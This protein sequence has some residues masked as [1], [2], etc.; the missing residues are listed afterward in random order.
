MRKKEK[1]QNKIISV[2][3]NTI[4]S[5]N[6]EDIK[7][8]KK[9]R[10]WTKNK[11][12][13]VDFLIILS[14]VMLDQLIKYYASTTLEQH[15]SI[16]LWEG[17]LQLTYL[18]NTGGIFGILQNQNF[19]ILFVVVILVLVVLYLLTKLPDKPRFTKLHI[20]LSCLLAGALGNLTDRI[21]F[22]YVIDF[23]YFVGIDFPIFNGADIL[24]STSTV[25][26]IIL[27]VFYY[28]EKD[29]D[30]LNFKQKR[31]RELK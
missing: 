15:G 31:Y 29:L 16:V 30:F 9:K 23:I 13:I 3:D 18:K 25:A 21:R 5:K 27:F 10:F 22:G 4:T 20:V 17:V 28:K 6:P 14:L 7:P 1:K 11:L 2:S 12:L 19:F 24:I 8:E 26:L